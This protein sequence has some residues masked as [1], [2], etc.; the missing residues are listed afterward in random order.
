MKQREH[1]AR[2][3]QGGKRDGGIQAESVHALRISVQLPCTLA[4]TE[5]T[6]CT[7]FLEMNTDSARDYITIVRL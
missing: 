3:E 4:T 5:R 7:Q 1:S 2:Q 6:M